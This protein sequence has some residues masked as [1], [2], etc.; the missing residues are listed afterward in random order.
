M[1][2]CWCVTWSLRERITFRLVRLFGDSGWINQCKDILFCNH[3]YHSYHHLLER[4]FN[5]SNDQTTKQKTASPK[6]KVPPSSIMFQ[7]WD[8]CHSKPEAFTEAWMKRLSASWRRRRHR[9]WIFRWWEGVPVISDDWSRCNVK[10][11]IVVNYSYPP[12]N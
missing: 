4:N 11:R 1:W 8:I 10:S 5:D 12:W 9:G 7:R 6:S 3:S 2:I